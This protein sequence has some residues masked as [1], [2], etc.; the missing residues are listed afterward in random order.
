MV[1]GL[2][3]NHFRQPPVALRIK[4]KF[5]GLFLWAEN[6][7]QLWFPRLW[8]LYLRL[9]RQRSPAD[10]RTDFIY[11]NIR[12][13]SETGHHLILS[14]RRDMTTF[15]FAIA[16]KWN[17]YL[18]LCERVI[19]FITIICDIRLQLGRSMAQIWIFFI[20]AKKLFEIIQRKKPTCFIKVL[21]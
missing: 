10:C 12:R 21:N 19:K 14:I 7:E 17:E 11:H 16:E 5:N 20:D 8:K 3:F 13:S 9:F 1:S 15:R 6:P 4:L 2:L 18:D